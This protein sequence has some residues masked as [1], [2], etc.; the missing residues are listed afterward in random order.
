MR[1]RPAVFNETEVRAAAGLTMVAGAVAFSYAYFDKQYVPLQ[2]M[3]TLFSV[4]FLIRVTVGLRY[5]P[6]GALAHAMTSRRQP[7]WVAARPK[8]FAWSLGLAM[9]LA[10]TVITNS[11]IRGYLPRTMCLICLTLMWLE[12]ALGLC[13]GCK[14]HALAV[15][16]GWTRIVPSGEVCV[17]CVREATGPGERSIQKPDRATPSRSAIA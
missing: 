8:R 11:G 2:V 1:A 15:R 9:A 4:E 3:A 6:F 10:M 14:I 13:V 5:S 17:D 16:R 7:D 12:S